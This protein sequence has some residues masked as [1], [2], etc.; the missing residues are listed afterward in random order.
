MTAFLSWIYNQ[1]SNVYLW[2][3]SSF[4]SYLN[5]VKNTWSLIVSQSNSA[6]DIAVA[7]ARVEINYV[8][9]N[10]NNVYAWATAQLQGVRTYASGLVAPVWNTILYYYNAAVN[11]AT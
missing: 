3:S 10:I 9:L 1:A 11:Y 2:F 8:G 4:G 7:W 5:T 6:Y